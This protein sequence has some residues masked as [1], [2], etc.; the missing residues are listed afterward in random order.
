MVLTNGVL[1][2]GAALGLCLMLIAG[3]SSEGRGEGHYQSGLELLGEGDV[4]RARVEVRNA[5]RLV[6]TH[7]E[8]R[9]QLGRVHR[10]SDNLT[11]AVREFRRVAE[12]LPAHLEA[13]VTLSAIAFMAHN[14]ALFDRRAPPAPQSSPE[15]PE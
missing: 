6:P 15:S 4:D 8:A 3:E 1:K 11:G 7:L 9:R 12:Q 13:P 10:M 14:W 5:L 2:V